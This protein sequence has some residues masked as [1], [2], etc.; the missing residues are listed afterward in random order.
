MHSVLF[1]VCCPCAHGGSKSPTSFVWW[2]W[3]A[4]PA[5]GRL[6]QEDGEFEASSDWRVRPCLKT[7]NK[8]GKREVGDRRGRKEGRKERREKRKE[9]RERGRKGRREGED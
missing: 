6:R 4:I 7:E 8:E 5:V 3:P 1:T 9:G 2:H